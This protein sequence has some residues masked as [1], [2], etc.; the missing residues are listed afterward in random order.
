[1]PLPAAGAPITAQMLA[2]LVNAELQT[3][4]VA[5]TTSTITM[6][7]TPQDLTASTGFTTTY[8]NT[9]MMCW[10]V[11]DVDASLSAANTFVG[12]LV[13]DGSTVSGGEAHLFGSVRATVTQMW[14]VTLAASGAHTIKLQG[15]Q[16][17]GSGQQTQATHTKVHA[18]IFGP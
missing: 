10:A 2:T 12:T 16:S 14:I 6:T 13:V 4:G 1:M 9:V 5:Q 15:K 18:L 11:F 17:A 3:L 7:T 8:A